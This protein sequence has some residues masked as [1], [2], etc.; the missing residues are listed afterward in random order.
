MATNSSTHVWKIPGMAEPGGLPSMR[1]QSQTQQ[2]RLSSSSSIPLCVCVCVREREREKIYHIFFFYSSVDE[3]LG[4]FQVLAFVNS[5]AMNIGV[6]VFFKIREFLSFPDTCPGVGLLGH[7]VT[8]FSVFKE[9]PHCC[10]QWL[11]QFTFPP[12]V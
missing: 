2:K 6:H 1:S 5:T 12:A 8:V 9:P 3:H 7:M 10:P 4:F 11:H